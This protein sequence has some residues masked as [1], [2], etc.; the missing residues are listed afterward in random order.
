[1]LSRIKE[2]R[3]LSL[4]TRWGYGLAVFLICLLAVVIYSN[5]FQSPFV[6][7]DQHTIQENAKIRDIDNFYTPDVLQSQRPLVDFTFALNYHF[8]KLRVFG[9]HVVNLFIHIATGILVFVLSQ[10]LFR[11]LTRNDD[12]NIYLSALFTALIFI[13]HPLQ[14]QAVTYI[15]QRYTSMAAFFYL[16]SVLSYIVARDAKS[17]GRRMAC[18]AFF[19]IA[20]AS[21]L[22]AFLCKQNAASLPLAILLI[23]YACYDQSLQGWLKKLGLIF[24]AIAL[25][26][27]FYAYNMGSLRHEMQFSTLLEDVSEMVRET[28]TVSRWQYFCTQFNVISNYI[29]LLLIPVHQNLDYL[30]PFKNGFFDGATPYSFVFLAGI[31]GVAWWSRKKQSTFFLGIFWFFITLSVESSFFPIRDAMFE[32]RLYLPMFGFSVVAGGAMG[33]LLTKNRLWA[34]GGMLAILISFSVSTYYRNQVWRDGISLWSDV[35]LKN[36]LNYRGFTNL[37]QTL[38]N[39][40][41]LKAALIQYDKA[42]RL[43]PD[44][45]IAITNKGS[46]LGQMGRPEEA[47]SLSREALRIKPNYPVALNNLGVALARMGNNDAAVTNLQMAVNIQ[48]NYAEAHFNLA[49]VFA[50]NGKLQAAV[51]QYL[52]V[53]RMDSDNSKAHNKIGVVLHLITRYKEAVYHFSEAIRTEPGNADFYLN[54]GNSQLALNLLNDAISSYREA[55]RLNPK[56]IEAVTNLGV[57]C[58]RAGNADEAVKQFNQALAINPDS[59]EAHANL[60]NALYSLGKMSEALQQLTIALRLKPGSPEIMNN[61][62]KI[63]RKTNATN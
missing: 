35:V 4:N 31:V 21:G 2:R 39:H 46:L 11:K 57:A 5:T 61:I 27:C 22:L 18:G 43:K 52:E 26:G 17:A 28:Q 51:E 16:G 56:S 10:I 54:L 3:I 6:F 50:N 41:N 29:R 32:H 42:L 23:E 14:T 1:M 24:P 60:G 62:N 36:P 37:G 9:Y 19:L 45:Y 7:D 59:V 49:T 53:L 55:A 38:Q 20:F 30:Y 58:L 47:V 12:R 34:Y 63:L 25:F 13:T 15:A 33:W 40:G 48:P 44:Y 8:G